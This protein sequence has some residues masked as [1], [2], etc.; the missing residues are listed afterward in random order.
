M[1]RCEDMRE[2]TYA[3]EVSRARALH[4]V[5]ALNAAASASA[6]HKLALCLGIVRRVGG[7]DHAEDEGSE[8]EENCE[9]AH[10]WI[11]GGLVDGL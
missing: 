10:C 8:R 11:V 3:T 7:G 1:K 4:V 2:R 6:L 5:A 9:G